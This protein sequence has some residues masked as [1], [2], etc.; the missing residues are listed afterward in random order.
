MNTRP[1]SILIIE[2][3]PLMREALCLAIEEAGWRV[4]ATMSDGIQ[5]LELLPGLQADLVLFSLG[6]P[7]LDD[8]QTI[9]ALRQAQPELPILALT[10]NELA[11]QEQAALR[12][13]ARAA[14]SKAS[15]RQELLGKLGELG[16]GVPM[17]SPPGR[18]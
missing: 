8:F 9:A 15:T 13:G 2:P 17:N 11:G 18:V 3:H 12:Y 6:N 7:G 10:A 1:V 14:L 16:A 4:A 5:A